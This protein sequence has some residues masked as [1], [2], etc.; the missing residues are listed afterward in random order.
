MRRS[1]CTCRASGPWSP[2]STKARWCWSRRARTLS[3][4]KL[5][6][7]AS[8]ARAAARVHGRVRR[9][10]GL[11]GR[12]PRARARRPCPTD[13]TGARPWRARRS[14]RPP[15]NA[16]QGPARSAGAL[17]SIGCSRPPSRPLCATR[18]PRRDG[19]SRARRRLAAAD[20]P[21]TTRT[22][23][24]RDR[25]RAPRACGRGF[26]GGLGRRIAGSRRCAPRSHAAGRL[27]LRERC[28][29]PQRRRRRQGLRRPDRLSR[30]LEP[31]RR[32]AGGRRA[33]AQGARARDGRGAGLGT[34]VQLPHAGRSGSALHARQVRHRR[35]RR[36]AGRGD[37][38]STSKGVGNRR[39]LIEAALT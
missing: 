25:S 37:A 31:E 33:R 8:A 2:R 12:V 10:R 14:N 9:Q 36:A 38:L 21:A 28:R 11:R 6:F 19:R 7:D 30:V 26:G 20:V 17:V 34:R 3:Q 13:A 22:A 39:P 18:K 35:H 23:G 29:V 1:R 32:S 24:C 16:E 27:G 5:P 15:A 4:L